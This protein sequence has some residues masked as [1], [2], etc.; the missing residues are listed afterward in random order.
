MR[1]PA[2]GS[3]DCADFA[4]PRTDQQHRLIPNDPGP[5]LAGPD[6]K[7][8]YS[9]LCPQDAPGGL[10]ARAMRQRTLRRLLGSKPERDIG[11]SVLSA[12][13]FSG[14]EAGGQR[15]AATA[16]PATRAA[17]YI[18]SMSHA[19][20]SIYASILRFSLS[21]G[22]I[23]VDQ[24]AALAPRLPRCRRCLTDTGNLFGRWSFPSMFRQRRAAD[25][26]ARLI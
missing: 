17:H 20:S 1:V 19:I 18:R 11:G 23:K 26:A 5:R 12:L 10:A 14:Y 25:T 24:I 8:A 7:D 13:C 6:E 15:M 3:G 16:P 21:E 2:A 4:P 22:A 9:L